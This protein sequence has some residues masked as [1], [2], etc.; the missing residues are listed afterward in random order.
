VNRGN[1]MAADI[2]AFKE[3]IQSRVQ[4]IWGIV[5]EPEPVFVGF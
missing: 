4:E 5:L 1:A 3:Y 2:V